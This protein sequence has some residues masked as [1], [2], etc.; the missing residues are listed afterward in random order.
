MGGFVKKTIA[1][2]LTIITASGLMTAKK[3]DTNNYEEKAVKEALLQTSNQKQ[4]DEDAILLAKTMYGEALITDSDTEIAAVAW[5][6][7][8]R[9]DDEKYPDTVKE[10]VSQ[11]YQFLG[12]KEEGEYSERTLRLAYDVLERHSKEKVNINVGRV[13]PDDYFFFEGD[14]KHNYFYKEYG[15]KEFYEWTMVSPYEN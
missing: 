3:A 8:N 15:K 4:Y 10:V 9:V 6:I 5:C 1:V 12:Y 11:P 13:L 2:I 7:L 14:G